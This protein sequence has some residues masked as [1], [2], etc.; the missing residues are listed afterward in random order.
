MSDH[1]FWKIGWRRSISLAHSI[2]LCALCSAGG[3]RLLLV[4]R[5]QLRC[6][7]ILP[8][9]PANRKQ[10]QAISLIIN[11]AADRKN[12]RNT[13]RYF[14]DLS[15]NVIQYE[16]DL[17]R[18][19]VLFT[20]SCVFS[21]DPT[22]WKERRGLGTCLKSSSR[23]LQEIITLNTIKWGSYS[24]TTEEQLNSKW[25]VKGRSVS[26]ALQIRVDS[27]WICFI[28]MFARKHCIHVCMSMHG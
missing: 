5:A 21:W 2:I 6:G 25:T 14:I 22:R 18:E 3:R 4:N 28:F 15:L 24:A 20:E 16:P 23:L 9:P 11:S 7:D 10:E 17:S 26:A 12:V 13:P 19:T 8:T 1:L 27:L